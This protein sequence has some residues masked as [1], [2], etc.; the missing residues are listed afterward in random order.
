MFI[1]ISFD[2]MFVSIFCNH[3]ILSNLYNRH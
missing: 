3:H 1:S 2:V